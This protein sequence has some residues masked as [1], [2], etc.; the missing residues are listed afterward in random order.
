MKQKNDR[1]TKKKRSFNDRFQKRL[2]TLHTSLFIF[3]YVYSSI[4]IEILLI[5]NYKLLFTVLT[6]LTRVGCFEWLA[7]S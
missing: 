4:K 1:K 7:L 3:I 2:T 6:R 5:S